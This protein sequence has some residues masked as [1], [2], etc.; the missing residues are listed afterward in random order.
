M[1]LIRDSISFG[2]VGFLGLLVDVIVLYCLVRFI[3]LFY[4]RAASF[5]VAVLTTWLLNRR[6]VFRERSSGL[7]RG[8][9][10]AT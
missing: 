8:S 7:T 9:E 2:L 5:L 3:G 4:G 6:L 1:R 10:L